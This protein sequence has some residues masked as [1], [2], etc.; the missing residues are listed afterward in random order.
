MCYEGMF[1]GFRYKRLKIV[2]QCLY[3]VIRLLEL[4]EIDT[5]ENFYTFQGTGVTLKRRGTIIHT[6]K[7]I[8]K[9]IKVQR[10]RI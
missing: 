9:K 8:V 4:E 10:N 7:K 3:I 5:D 1:L 2:N 6:S